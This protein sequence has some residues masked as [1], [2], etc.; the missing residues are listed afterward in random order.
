MTQKIIEKCATQKLSLQKIQEEIYDIFNYIV[1][2][3]SKS[4]VFEW[5]ARRPR[6]QTFLLVSLYTSYTNRI[7][8]CA[9]PVTLTFFKS[10]FFLWHILL[11]C[12]VQVVRYE[13][14]MLSQSAHIS[15]MLLFTDPHLIC[16]PGWSLSFPLT[17]GFSIFV[18]PSSL[19]LRAY[20]ITISA[21]A[22]PYL[23]NATES[24]TLVIGLSEGTT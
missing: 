6:I 11:H 8:Q 13:I 12:D 4:T 22:P 21:C 3:K 5:R 20:P 14:W 19:P 23:V 24:W 9:P 16:T 17:S 18:F 10:S 1:T 7:G 15:K 2:F